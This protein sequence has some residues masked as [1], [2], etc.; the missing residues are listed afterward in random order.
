MVARFTVG[1]KKPSMRNEHCV[2]RATVSFLGMCCTVIAGPRPKVATI[3]TV[4]V[5]GEDPMSLTDLLTSLQVHNASRCGRSG[6]LRVSLRTGKFSCCPSAPR[7]TVHVKV[8][9]LNSLA[10]GSM[11]R[12]AASLFLLKLSCRESRGAGLRTDPATR[13]LSESTKRLCTDLSTD[14][15]T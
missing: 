2:R 3:R 7:A 11:T 10:G 8:V 1:S 5:P 15:H 6:V 12:Q 4:A 14:E 9:V 13:N